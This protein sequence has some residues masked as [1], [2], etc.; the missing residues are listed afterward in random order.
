[1]VHF[2]WL[3]ISNY[4]SSQEFEKKKIETISEKRFKGNVFNR[5]EYIL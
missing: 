2:W 3:I 4:T 5:T 1:M